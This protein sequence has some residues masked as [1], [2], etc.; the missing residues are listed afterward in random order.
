MSPRLSDFLG[1]LAFSLF[2]ALLLVLW[3]R[4]AP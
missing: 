1:V 4:I 2:L 3:G